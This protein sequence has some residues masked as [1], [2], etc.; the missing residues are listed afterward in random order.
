VWVWL[1]S[2]TVDPHGITSAFPDGISRSTRRPV[3]CA[4]N[5]ASGSAGPEQVTPVLVVDSNY[6][7]TST[8]DHIPVNGAGETTCSYHEWTL[9]G[10][11]ELEERHEMASACSGTT[12]RGACCGWSTARPRGPACS[13]SRI[14]QLSQ[15][16]ELE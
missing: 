12:A 14:G 16:H 5:P 10:G 3:R 6:S 9:Q 4:T 8:V 1:G 15:K 7:P 2:W 11:A 13:F